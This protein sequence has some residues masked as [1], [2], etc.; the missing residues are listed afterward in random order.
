MSVPSPTTASS[1]YRS[2]L[3]LVVKIVAI[4][5]VAKLLLALIFSRL[6]LA[7][8][9]SFA[10][11]LP[12]LF[13]RASM[14]SVRH[15]PVYVPTIVNDNQPDESELASEEQATP[16]S[17]QL[18]ADPATG[19]DVPADMKRVRWFVNRMSYPC[20]IGE[21]PEIDAFG[22]KARLPLDSLCSLSEKARFKP[23]VLPCTNST[24]AVIVISYVNIAEADDG[25]GKIVREVNGYLFTKKQYKK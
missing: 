13:G 3:S 2:R 23:V 14:Q 15:C 7:A 6:M 11:N 12:L 4:V 5:C 8:L 10:P 16:W 22:F 1:S 9:I 17:L 25:E 18:T 21:H 19:I 20:P 24:K